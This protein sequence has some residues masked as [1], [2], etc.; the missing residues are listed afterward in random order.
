MISTSQNS[1]LRRYSSVSEVPVE[2]N[3]LRKVASLTLEKNT[4]ENKINKP[5]FVPEKLDFQ[6]YEKFEG[7]DVKCVGVK[8]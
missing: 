5:K 6:L 4:I 3:V 8:F 1:H 7:K 2:N